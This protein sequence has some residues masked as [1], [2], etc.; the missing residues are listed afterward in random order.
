LNLQVFEK[1]RFIFKI[2]AKLGLIGWNIERIDQPG[3]FH[4]ISVTIF[5][6]IAYSFV[7]NPYTNLTDQA[8]F[9]VVACSTET[10]CS[11]VAL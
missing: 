10:P 5:S 3:N 9:V 11:T 7:I 8:A 2:S 1:H 4:S 6:T